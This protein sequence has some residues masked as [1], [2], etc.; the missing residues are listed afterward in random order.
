MIL[1]L[2]T[3]WKSYNLKRRIKCLWVKEG[4]IYQM[5]VKAVSLSWVISLATLVILPGLLEH[6]DLPVRF[7]IRTLTAIMLGVLGIAYL[8]LSFSSRNSDRA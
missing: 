8:C 3:V 4:Y 6:I 5:M 2:L 7:Y 1:T